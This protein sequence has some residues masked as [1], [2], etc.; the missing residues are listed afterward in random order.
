MHGEDLAFNYNIKTLLLNKWSSYQRN[1]SLF[2][3]G[4]THWAQTWHKCE[5]K[6]TFY[7]IAWKNKNL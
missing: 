4:G 6:C 3:R 7:E 2:C 1:P 5:Y